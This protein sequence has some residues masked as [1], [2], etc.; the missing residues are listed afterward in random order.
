MKV[1]EHTLQDNIAKAEAYL[2]TLP[3]VDLQTKHS[4]SGGMYARTIFIPAGTTMTG[5]THKTDHLDVMQGDVM[6]TLGDGET[7]R[8]T[9]HHVLVT[10]AGAKRIG[11][12]HTDTIWTTI[13]RTDLTDIQEIESELVVEAEQLQTRQF[14][15]EGRDVYKLEH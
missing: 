1:A 5:A 4:I 8:L 6:F 12:A 14:A 9:G 3:Q 10:K 15:L 13:C 2:L 11:H 7:K